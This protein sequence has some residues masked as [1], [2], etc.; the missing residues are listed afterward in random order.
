MML[1]C[2][3]IS[4]LFSRLAASSSSS[5]RLELQR[6]TS[7]FRFYLRS[8]ARSDLLPDVD[9]TSDRCHVTDVDPL[10][11]FDSTSGAR[12]VIGDWVDVPAGRGGILGRRRAA[13]KVG[14]STVTFLSP[15]RDG[16]PSCGHLPV[17]Q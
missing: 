12:H 2:S 3:N 7:G 1:C 8:A 4:T 9:S 6:S 14:R 16:R 15:V 10:P 5:S 11:V 13:G 17:S